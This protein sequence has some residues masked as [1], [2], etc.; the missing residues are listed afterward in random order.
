MLSIL[1]FSQKPIF[2]A[3][4]AG[5]TDLPFR[6]ICKS[7]GADAVITEMV[8]TRG[9]YYGDKKTC[10]LLEINPKEHP[11]GAQLFGNDPSFFQEAVAYLSDMPFDFI[12][13]NMGCPTPKI[14]KNGDGCALMKQP[15]I[16]GNIVNII[17]KRA[18][19]PVTVKIRKG[20]DDSQVNA[21]Q[22][23]R[24]LEEN[25]A[26]MIIVHG[27]TRDAF[28]S[29]KADWGIIREVKNAVNIPVIGNGDIFTPEDAKN[30]IEQ[31][32][33]DGIMVGRGA[34]GNPWIF[35]EIKHYFA[36]GNKLSPP[37]NQEKLDIMQ[38]HLT[39]AIEFYGERL[40]ILEMRKHFAWYLKGLPHSASVKQRIQTTR[41]IDELNDMIQDFFKDLGI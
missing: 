1:D 26:E 29:G 41:D 32:G 39:L 6:S 17:S 16:S 3:P 35:R 5:I 11:I 7:F 8:S 9:I 4:M 27:R 36:T 33:C 10:K 14:V 15:V 25:G 2:L 12:N 19:I 40:G 22:F 21:A 38:R 30:M 20:W 34:M 24:M 18:K 13:I 28:Y 31:T 37:T 23:S